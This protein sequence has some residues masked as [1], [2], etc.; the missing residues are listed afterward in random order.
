MS[1]QPD[2]SAVR[3]LTAALPVQL[4]EAAPRILV[5]GDVMLD[6]WFSGISER[7][8]RE[9]PA[10]VVDLH[11]RVYA[12]GGAANTA[13]NLAALGAR[14]AV[15]G[16]AGD[17]E[18]GRRLASLLAEGGVEVSGLQLHP[19]L[20]TTTKYRVIAGDQVL[21]RMDDGARTLPPDAAAGLARALPEQLADVDAV[22]VCDYGSGLL[23]GEVRQALEAHRG[24]KLVLVDAHEPARWADLRPDLI[25]PNAAETGAMLGLKLDPA[26][27]R[28][29]EVARHAGRIRSLA[30]AGAA[31]VTLDRDGALLLAGDGGTH[32]TW[33]RPATEKQASGAGDTFVACLALARACGLPPATAVDLAQSAADIV[34]QRPG[35][36]VC[37]TTDLVSYLGS[38]GDTALA[39]E[40]LLG[41]IALER[42][43]G[44]TV[45]LTNGC[46]DVLHRGHTRYLNQAKALGDV[47]VVAL[48]SDE[49]T[50]RLKGPD[51][52]IN[53][54]H[55]RAG[56]IAALSCVDYVTVFD[57]DTPIP[58]IEA[59]RPDIYAKG[60]D[61]SPQMLEETP[62]VEACGGQVRILDYVADR[63]TT[64]VVERIRSRPEAGTLPGQ[65]PGPADGG[66]P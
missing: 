23:H 53:P 56:V 64:A 22:L 28:A 11:R 5:V 51:R 33:A 6:G 10:P 16:L 1:A 66:R 26:T 43:A 19:D 13:M 60:G 31:V 35:T 17:D 4:A 18:A 65:E 34:V 29:A 30:G 45:V 36:S 40:E 46:F 49:S 27:D 61:Y 39:P 20:Q 57:T 58:L 44:K 42:D 41:R 37:T 24:G 7:L 48:N 54:L 3:G 50:R 8:C 59:L 52:P 38:L 12:P 47:L 25:T 14:V 62:V 2:F 15:A 55:D 9:A 32:R 63:S 21:L